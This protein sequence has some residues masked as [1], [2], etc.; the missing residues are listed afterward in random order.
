MFQARWVEKTGPP[1]F[2]SVVRFKAEVFWEDQKV[3]GDPKRTSTRAQRSQ[4]FE[5]FCMAISLTLCI[6]ELY[7][8]FQSETCQ[9]GSIDEIPPP[10][11][12]WRRCG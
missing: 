3:V 9:G 5:A 8:A 6:S 7:S 1:V 2:T 4:K 11:N 10:H 12:E